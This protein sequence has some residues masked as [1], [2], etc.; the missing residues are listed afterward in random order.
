MK[1]CPACQSTFDDKVDFCFSDGT[2]LV[3]FDAADDP[4]ALPG[5]ADAS[6]SESLSDSKLTE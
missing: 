6:A 4:T 2:P 1:Q 5:A 3:A